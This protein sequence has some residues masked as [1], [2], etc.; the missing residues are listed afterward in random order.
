MTGHGGADKTD[1]LLPELIDDREVRAAEADRFRHA[2]V[3]EELARLAVTV[4]TPANVALY[5]PWGSGKSG[6]ANLLR[7][8]LED[9]SFRKLHGTVSFVRFDAFKY[10]EIPLRRHFLSQLA[11]ELMDNKAADD[12]RDRLYRSE[13]RT[14]INF[15]S[16]DVWRAV[17]V[18]LLLLLIGFALAAAITAIAAGAATRHS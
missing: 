10:A 9:P 6:V 3:A 14:D 2:D 16:L 12:F 8:C 18:F 11:A 1:A 7:E 17:R 5:G 15:R 13:S 4:D